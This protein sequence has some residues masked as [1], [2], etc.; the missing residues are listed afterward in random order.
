MRFNDEATSELINA[1]KSGDVERM[2][3]ALTAG[4]DPDVISA[5]EPLVCF[6]AG[7]SAFEL[8]VLETLLDAGANPNQPDEWGTSALTYAVNKGKWLRVGVLIKAGADINFQHEKGISKT[9]LFHAV[10]LDLQRGDTTYT[11]CVLGFRPDVS[12]KMAMGDLSKCKTV[13]EHL[14]ELRKIDPAKASLMDELHALIREY[15]EQNPPPQEAAQRN[16]AAERLAALRRK[17]G[18]KPFKL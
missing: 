14:Q 18:N 5:C 13:G 17:S 12:L 8:D 1:T 4:G 11:S 16:Q 3:A 9:A 10:M 6:A 7:S 15:A 2:R